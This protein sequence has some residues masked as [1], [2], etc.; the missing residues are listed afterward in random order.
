MSYLNIWLVKTTEDDDNLSVVTIDGKLSTSDQDGDK[1]KAYEYD[2]WLIAA[3]R[4]VSM[5]DALNDG[6]ALVITKDIS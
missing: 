6:E 1:F 4:V 5:M 3:A 2:E